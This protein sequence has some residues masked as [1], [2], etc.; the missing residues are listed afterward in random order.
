MLRAPELHIFAD[1]QELALQAA[2]FFLLTGA[3]AIAERGRFL[4]VLSGGSTPKTLYSILTSPEYS[5]RIDW[6]KVHFLFGDERAV[7]PSHTDSN[8]AM[9][10]EHLFI[11]LRIPSTQIHRMRGEDEPEAAALQYENTLRRLTAGSS[12]QW[13]VLDLVLLGMGDD[14]HIASLFPGSP[15]VD[16]R[17]RWVVPSLAPQGIRSRLTLTLGVIN[18]AGV[19]LFLVTGP[20]KAK[21]IR[22]VVQPQLTDAGLYPAA[23]VQP[24]TGRLIW[25]LD[26]GAASELNL[27]R[28]DRH[29]ERNT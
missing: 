23:L 1:A 5:P 16:E 18:H 3:L 6:A 12:G 27:S 2:D 19:I 29:R 21:V 15:S 25:Y 7:S 4:V 24:E 11:P 8:F 28:H 14:G 26:Q 20:N 9:A 10:N 17:T 13:P 22:H